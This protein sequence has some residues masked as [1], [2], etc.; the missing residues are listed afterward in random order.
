MPREEMLNTAESE[1]GRREKILEFLQAAENNQPR[2]RQD[3]KYL[4]VNLSTRWV[5]AI[6]QSWVLMTEVVQ[7]ARFELEMVRWL[8]E[9]RAEVDKK[10]GKGKAQGQ[11]LDCPHGRLCY[12]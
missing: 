11:L 3:E 10:E 12:Q 5:A 9:D 1:E 2:V 8:K 7:H 6:S 4:V